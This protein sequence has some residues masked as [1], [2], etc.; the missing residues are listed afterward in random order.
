MDQ[1]KSRLHIP[2]PASNPIPKNRISKCQLER[3]QIS[4]KDTKTKGQISSAE[5]LRCSRTSFG[6]AAARTPLL[7]KLQPALNHWM[8]KQLLQGVV[9]AVVSDL[10]K[11]A[12]PSLLQVLRQMKALT[13][14]DA[15]H[16]CNSFCATN[17]S[18]NM[19]FSTQNMYIYYIYI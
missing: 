7:C 5:A 8:S 16:L 15:N 12:K 9:P 14:H 2:V 19:L 4:F 1:N 13:H 11:V 3:Q 6:L 18:T 10:T 17:V